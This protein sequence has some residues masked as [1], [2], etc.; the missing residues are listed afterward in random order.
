MKTTIDIADSLLDEARR[1]AAARRTTLRAL[2]EQG[3][4]REIEESAKPQ[5][6]MRDLRF[7]SG[8]MRPGFET[9]EQIRDEIYRGRGA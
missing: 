1:V 6:K 7:G 9:W 2:V 8:G 4:R 5:R 3:L